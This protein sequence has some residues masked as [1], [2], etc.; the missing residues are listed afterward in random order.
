[1]SDD[2]P[3][4]VMLEREAELAP[5]RVRF[6]EWP[7]YGATVLLHLFRD[8]DPTLIAKLAPCYRVLSLELPPT[9]APEVSASHVVEFIEQFGFTNVVVIAEGPTDEIAA[10]VERW[11]PER[12]AGV[13]NIS[14]DLSIE[15]VTSFVEARCRRSR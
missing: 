11:C 5:V 10:L 7:G 2:D 8:A 14:D 6:R 1:V 3:L 9:R 13:L 12:V 4:S 15:A